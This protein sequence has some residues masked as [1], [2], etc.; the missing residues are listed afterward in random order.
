M[1][2]KELLSILVCPEARTPL[3]LA[4]QTLLA[5]VNRAISGGQVRNKGGET[6]AETLDAA[7]VR[8]DRAVLY[9]IVDRIPILLLDAGIALD[10]GDVHLGAQQKPS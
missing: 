5:A 1:I 2:S 10:Q 3:E 7:L 8:Q 6:V 9:P 4:D